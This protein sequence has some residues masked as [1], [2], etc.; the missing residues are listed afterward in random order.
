MGRPGGPMGENLAAMAMLPMQTSPDVG[1]ANLGSMTPGIR[2][3]KKEDRIPQWGY[4]ETKEFIA[5]RAELEKDFMQ[6]KRNKT[7]WEFIAGKMKEKGYHRSADQCKCKWKN[8]VNQYKGKETSEVDNGK[9]PFFEELDAI[10]KDRAKNMDR[11]MLLEAEA[12]SRPRKKGKLGKPPSSD[13]D[14]DDD[15]DEDN[16]SEDRR[17]NIGARKSR[18]SV[19]G[20][21]VTAE[22]FR[23]NSMQE[24]LEEFFQ[25]QQLAEE[26]WHDAVERREHERHMREQEWRE[27]MEKLEQERIT[28]EQGWREREE[29]RRAREEARA[30]KRDELFAALLSKLAQEGGY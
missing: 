28:R 2:R 23:A 30:Q 8:L 24:V 26:H 10:F 6:T 7:L 1:V 12:G 15:N 18:K 19:K 3:S 27:A 14:S 9:L 4:D 16:D 25:Q 5:M 13:E 22:K 21:R 29:Q 11:M 17:I 20:Q